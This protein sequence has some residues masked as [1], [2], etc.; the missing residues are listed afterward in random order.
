VAV[1]EEDEDVL[2]TR[3]EQDGLWSRSEGLCEISVR[4]HVNKWIL[5]DDSMI[6]VFMV[7][8]RNYTYNFVRKA[9]SS[10]FTILYGHHA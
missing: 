4:D 9:C 2:S 3:R 10:N 5:T 7:Y 6:E 1:L 8:E